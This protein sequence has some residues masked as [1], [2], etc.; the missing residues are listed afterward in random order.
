MCA[1]HTINNQTLALFLCLKL[2]LRTFLSRSSPYPHAGLPVQ[3]PRPI[4]GTATIC[5]GTF[6]PF[7]QTLYLVS[8][9]VLLTVLW[10]FPNFYAPLHLPAAP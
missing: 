3:L 4:N 9:Q 1:W 5:L 10:N 7:T 8:H 2:T 6:E